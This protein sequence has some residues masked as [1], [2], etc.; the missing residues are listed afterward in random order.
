MSVRFLDYKGS[1]EASPVSS[2]D[3]GNA[4]DPARPMGWGRYWLYRL[5][6]VLRDARGATTAEY[7]LLLAL[8]VIVL[9]GTLGAL[10]QALD[11][12]INGI[13]DDIGNAG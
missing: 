2:P 7:A 6:L 10:G 9:I 13:I 1:R 5:G 11:V 8:V 4:P 12:K 3:S